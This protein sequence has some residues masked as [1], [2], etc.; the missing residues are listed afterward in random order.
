MT[1]SVDAKLSM[2]LLIDT[3]SGKVV[4]AEADKNCVDFLSHS[5]MPVGTVIRLLKG[6]GMNGCLPNLYESVENL[7]DN[8]IQSSEAIDVLLNP[9]SSVGISS[10][11]L[12]FLDDVP[13]E[14]SRVVYECPSGCSGYFTEDPAAECPYCEDYV[15]QKLMD[16]TPPAP[17]TNGFVKDVVTYMI[18]DYEKTSGQLVNKDKS[19]FLTDANVSAYRINRIRRCT[20]NLEKKFPFTY[21]VALSA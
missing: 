9:K 10:F 17:A 5:L 7:N 3:K 20:G 2:N 8:Y 16:V 11:P 14:I 12:L 18:K 4:F 15:V 21:L 19:Y 13:T 1:T 6:K